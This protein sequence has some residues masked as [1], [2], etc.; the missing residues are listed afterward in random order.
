M[1]AWE[2]ARENF[3]NIPTVVMDDWP[4]IIGFGVIEAGMGW[5]KSMTP[6]PTSMTA[7][8]IQKS[9]E[10]GLTTMVKFSYWEGMSKS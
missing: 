9:L 3:M 6:D 2:I 8:V 1:S 5:L 7:A 10:E 4:F